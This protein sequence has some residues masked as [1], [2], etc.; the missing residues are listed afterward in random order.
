MDS[1]IAAV[2]LSVIAMLM[3]FVGLLSENSPAAEG[4]AR[5]YL[6]RVEAGDIEAGGR[7]LPIR[8]KPDEVIAKSADEAERLAREA[9]LKQIAEAYPGWSLVEGSLKI[10]VIETPDE[11]ET[12]KVNATLYCNTGFL[13]E[14]KPT[15]QV[16]NITVASEDDQVIDTFATRLIVTQDGEAPRQFEDT[17]RWSGSKHQQGYRL[18]FELFNGALIAGEPPRLLEVEVQ[19]KNPVGED[20]RSIGKF[21]IRM[22]M[23]GHRLKVDWLPI[24]NTKF[25]G[26]AD[27]PAS[28]VARLA[29]DQATYSAIV[30]ISNPAEIAAARAAEREKVEDMRRKLEAAGPGL[31]VVQGGAQAMVQRDGNQN[32]CGVGRVF[33]IGDDEIAAQEYIAKYFPGRP[34]ILYMANEDAARKFL[35]RIFNES[36]GNQKIVSELEFSIQPKT[37]R[38]TLDVLREREQR[39]PP[40]RR[41]AP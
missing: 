38:T 3:S 34:D 28:N 6:Y 7:K 24:T 39:N 10:S 32:K 5:R 16:F 35:A 33:V 4:G 40:R 1:R 23:A 30:R 22:R 21:Q 12:T 41:P 19:Q 36:F 26:N 37:G 31:R 17:I 13:K 2:R 18:Q 14:G 20:W 29:S 25:T 8:L 27:S 9:V 15:L 11:D